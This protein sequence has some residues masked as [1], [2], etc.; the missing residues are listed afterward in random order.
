MLHVCP[1]GRISASS[2]FGRAHCARRDEGQGAAP[3]ARRDPYL[4]FVFVLQPEGGEKKPK[5]QQPFWFLQMRV[6]CRRLVLP[7]L[8]FPTSI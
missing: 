4:D 1:A 2:G 6:L 7:P 8:P 5:P 3:P